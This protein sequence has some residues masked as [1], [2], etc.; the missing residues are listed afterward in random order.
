MVEKK[1]KK[2]REKQLQYRWANCVKGFD[3][4]LLVQ[5]EPGK[6][7]WIHPTPERQSAACKLNSL[8]E[9]S[10]DKRFYVKVKK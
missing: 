4:P 2:G 9:F 6:W 1:A 10:V 8:D 3:L 7:S 5:L